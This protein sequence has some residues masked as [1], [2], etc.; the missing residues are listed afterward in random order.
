MENIRQEFL[1]LTD[2]ST[3]KHI[4]TAIEYCK[5]QNPENKNIDNYLQTALEVGKICINDINLSDDTLIVAVLYFTLN[6][7][8]INIDDINE[9]FSANIANILKGLLRIPDIQSAKLDMQAENFIKLLLTIN[10]DIN[11]IL[12]KLAEVLNTLRNVHTKP[13]EMQKNIASIVSHLYAPMAHRLGLYAIKT[14]MEDLSMKYLNN[15]AY[16]EIAHKLARSKNEREAYI[17][18]FIAP[19]QKELDKQ[20]IKCQIKGRPKSISSIWKKIKTQGVDFEEVYDK[21]AIRIIIDSEGKNEKNDCWRVYSIITDWY[22][23]NPNRLRDWISSPKLSGYESLHTTVIGPEQKWVEVQ[24]RTERMD[25]I[26]EK[27]H[28]AHW[29][30]KEKKEGSG[31]DW[32]AEIRKSLEQTDAEKDEEQAKNKALLYTDEIFLFTPK[33]DLRKAKFGHTVLDFAFSIHSDIGEKCTG[34]IINDKIVPIKHKLKNGDNIKI[35]TAKNQKPRYEWLEIVQSG[36]AKSKIRKALKIDS[37]KD[38]ELGKDII[39]YK[40]SQLKIEFNDANVHKMCK[41][42]DFKSYIDLYQAVGVGKLDIS[43]LKKA[44]VKPEPELAKSDIDYNTDSE[45]NTKK[46][47]HSKD[48]LVIDDNLQSVDYQL[49][50]CCNPIPGDEIFGFVTVS[51]GIKIHKTTCTNSKDMTSRYPYRIIKAVW[52]DNVELDNFM[53]KIKITGYDNVGASS[54]ILQIIANDFNINI[55]SINTQVIKNNMFN[56]FVLMSISNKKQLYDLIN[57]LQKINDVAEV[58]R[59]NL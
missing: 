30:Y 27:G 9:K 45:E 31:S 53:A 49:S 38:S 4:D 37:Y 24:I 14:E 7:E 54:E 40:L 15:T 50:K 57:R 51:K 55:R 35:L 17:K 20:K 32:L 21:F 13:V 18:A 42:F 39:K 47:I 28:A 22:K 48:C 5:L 58:V 6:R 56:A 41:Y 23:P 12:I 34:A 36:R 11:S 16:K 33:G 2:S 44:F 59:V 25:E 46:L 1:K 52:K 10:P 43:K 8:N 3:H 29:K 19:I 26:A